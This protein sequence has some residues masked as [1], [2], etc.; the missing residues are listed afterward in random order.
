MAK[1]GGKFKT[2]LL[3]L[4]LLA[5]LAIVFVLLGGGAWLKSAGRWMTG[6][7]KEA[8]VVKQKMEEKASS[9]GKAV[10]KAIDTVKPGEKAGEK[11]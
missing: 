10:E 1:K 9:T 4:M 3:T 7:G 6:V 11:K 5:L 2:F 8:D